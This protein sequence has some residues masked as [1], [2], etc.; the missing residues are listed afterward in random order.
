MPVL[1]TSKF[2]SYE[3]ENERMWAASQ[4]LTIDQECYIQNLLAEAVEE[5][6]AIA[7]PSDDPNADQIFIRSH[8]YLRGQ[9]EILQTILGNSTEARKALVLVDGSGA[10]LQTD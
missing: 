5:K 4:V 10:P 8:E 6:M 1:K 2:N 7:P 3:F 9:V